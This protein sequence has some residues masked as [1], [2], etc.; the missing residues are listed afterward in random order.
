MHIKNSAT[1]T[2]IAAATTIVLTSHDAVVQL[3]EQQQ[4]AKDFEQGMR[5]DALD[6]LFE[7]GRF[8]FGQDTSRFLVHLLKVDAHQE[9]ILKNG[10]QVGVLIEQVLQAGAVLVDGFGVVFVFANLQNDFQHQVEVV[11]HD[12]VQQLVGV[13]FGHGRALS[14]CHAANGIIVGVIVLLVGVLFLVQIVTIVARR[15]IGA[16]IAS[17]TLSSNPSQQ[18][19]SHCRFVLLYDAS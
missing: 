12:F 2:T 9:G 14:F 5:H 7:F 3:F 17:A 15:A 11:A 4:K 16:S 18:F 13:V 1:S 6:D 10:S 8:V 19:G